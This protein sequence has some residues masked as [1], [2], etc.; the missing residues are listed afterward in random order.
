MRGSWGEGMVEDGFS[1]DPIT[2]TTIIDL[3]STCMV[4]SGGREWAAGWIFPPNANRDM[5]PSMRW[6]IHRDWLLAWRS[7]TANGVPDCASVVRPTTS[8]VGRR[9]RLASKLAN[10][11]RAR[12]GQSTRVSA[13]D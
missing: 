8:P 7:C 11:K 2:Q 13:A 10:E 4:G 5:H 9:R 1:M 12:I 6:M 3:I